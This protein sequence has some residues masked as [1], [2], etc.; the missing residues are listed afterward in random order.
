MGLPAEGMRDT[1]S[2]SGQHFSS[3]DAT[4]SV[5]VSFRSFVSSDPDDLDVQIASLLAWLGDSRVDVLE[6]ALELLLA[7]IFHLR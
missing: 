3:R 2:P 6:P 1:R 7:D 5:R 4:I